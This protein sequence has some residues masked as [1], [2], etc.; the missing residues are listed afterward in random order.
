MKILFKNADILLKGEKF[1]VLENAFLAVDGDKIS[2]IGSEEPAD[3]FD[4]IKDMS[5]KMLIPGLINC[6]NH[7]PMVLLR[8]VGSDLPLQQWLFDTV[9]PIED[10]LTAEE[11]KSGSELALLEMISGG[12]VSFSDMYFEPEMTIEAVARSG[13]KANITRPVQS[14]DSSETPDQ[15]YRMKEAIELYDKYNDSF[16]GR[17]LIDFC[18]HAEY[19]CTETIARAFIEKVNERK[20]NLHI[21]LS[22]TKKEH[23]ECVA[24]YGKTPAEWFDSLGGFDSSAFAAHCVWLTDSDMELFRRKNVNVVH[25]PT[26]NM[27][28]AS[29]FAPVQRMLD[30]GINVALGTDGASSN[31]NLDML[32][33]MHIASIIHNGYNLDATVMNADTVLRMATV[34]GAKV[35]RR[36]NCGE[37]KVGNKAD[38]VA[39]SLDAPH[40]VP[41]LDKKALLTYSAQSSD[42]VM[43]MADGKIL[44]ENG[45]YK[46]L[47]REKIYFDVKKA[48]EKLYK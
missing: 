3:N 32:E 22:E 6:H 1:D 48:V 4:E 21:H 19:T 30:M 12:T 23:D 45:E 40:M 17:V 41:T 15:S 44:Y 14:F 35:Q 9:F 28:L 27:K 47:D 29:G 34:N 42:V 24:K 26:S 16:D 2:Y 46:T 20:G 39:I 36:E 25:N 18:I 31:N 5:G 8:G 38:I 33:E 13:M 10:K 43:T 7:C 37:L 11:I